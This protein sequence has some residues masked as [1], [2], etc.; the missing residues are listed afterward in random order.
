MELKPYGG[1]DIYHRGLW[2]DKIFGQVKSVIATYGDTNVSTCSSL[3][4]TT[5]KN[6]YVRGQVFPFVNIPIRYGEKELLGLYEYFGEVLPLSAEN[7]YCDIVIHSIYYS[8]DQ[9]IKD[10]HALE[11]K[12]RQLFTDRKLEILNFEDG[13]ATFTIPRQVL[14]GEGFAAMLHD[15]IDVAVKMQSDIK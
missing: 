4:V 3:C 1:L 9:A 7:I 14:D 12:A 8:E 13:M 15:L 5:L 10:K 6:S 11:A 2:V